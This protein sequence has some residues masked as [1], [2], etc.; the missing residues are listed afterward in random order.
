MQ[1]SGQFFLDT[2]A[3]KR[4]LPAHLKR[5]PEPRGRR[6]ESPTDAR[7]AKDS[8]VVTRGGIGREALQFEMPE[9]GIFIEVAAF[10]E[11]I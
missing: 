8:P 9:T 7:Q 10:P 6:R 11:P 5:V 3:A 1:F 2:T 4:H